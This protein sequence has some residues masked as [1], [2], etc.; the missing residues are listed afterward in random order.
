MDEV[1]KATPRVCVVGLGKIGLPLAVQFASAGCAVR[2]A[3]I[4]RRVVEAVNAGAEPFP[5]EAELAERL[6]AVLRSGQL[7]ATTDTVAAVADSDVV[8]VVVPLLVNDSGDP[9]YGA[10]DAATESIGAGLRPGTIVIYETTLPVFTTRRRFA[11]ALA[12][13]SGLALGRELFVAFSPER[14]YSGRIFADLR[15]YPKL[16]GAL[17]DEGARRAVDFYERA[18]EFDVR[19]DLPRLNGVWDLGSAEAAELTKLAETTYRDLNIAFANELAAF[20][21]TAAIDVREVI[22]AANSQP[23]SHIHRPG[24]A[25][26][27]HCIPVYPRFL[28]MNAPDARLPAVAREVNESVPPRA[29]RLLSS[30]L[31]GLADVH[32]V[33]LGAAYRGNVK[34]TAFS[35]VFPTVAALAEH[36]AHVT[37]HDPLFDDGELADLG[38]KPYRIGDHVDALVLQA[39]HDL[40]MRL[41]PAD[42]PGVRVVLDGRDVLDPA[43]WPGINMIRLGV[44][45]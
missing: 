32:V 29:V 12:A 19:R 26:G 10:L 7:S 31:A 5:G 39:D 44:G 22:D 20:A 18:L 9:E 30:Q 13:R 11:P 14:V 43:Q 40:Y 23:F 33:V 36:G 24:I 27:G 21:E 38:L 25:V 6:G 35:G 17:D 4:D 8:I 37:V 3:D 28:L 15:R 41:G 2:G 34:E 1:T 42:F 45:A 16:V